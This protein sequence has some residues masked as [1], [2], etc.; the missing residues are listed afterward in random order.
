M[1]VTTL[2]ID[3]IRM[4]GDDRRAHILDSAMR[5]LSEQGFSGFSINKLAK[6]CDLTTAGL[7]HHFKS[8]DILVV[9]LLEERDRRD[10]QALSAALKPTSR[11]KQSRETVL[12]VLHAIVA[13]NATQPHL[14]RLNAM[15]RAEALVLEH[16][17]RGY[18]IKRETGVRRSIA[19]LVR[20]HAID[21]EA[22]AM[23][24]VA[25]M[26]GLEAQWISEACAF[27]ITEAWDRAAD[28]LLC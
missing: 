13:R 18:I 22:T 25:L 1:A 20:P 12:E 14:V 19:D 9:A 26:N 5:L 17:A 23:Q 6:R 21:A 11:F 16:P 28:K 4:K 24:I 27:D 8:K 2:D 7:L 10:H 15:I 3:K